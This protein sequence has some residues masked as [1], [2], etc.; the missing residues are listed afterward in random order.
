MLNMAYSKAR[1]EGSST[2]QVYNKNIS[3]QVSFWCLV[4]LVF[5]TL[6]CLEFT[7]N[8][9]GIKV[10]ANYSWIVIAVVVV[11]II[12]NGMKIANLLIHPS[13]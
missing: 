1:Q 13:P 5:K 10:C 6:N 8:R 12:F 2:D 3:E 9:L 4:N 7:Y 11:W